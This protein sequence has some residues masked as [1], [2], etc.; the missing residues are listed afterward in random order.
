MALA[1]TTGPGGELSRTS[2][3]RH[4]G[5]GYQDLVGQRLSGSAFPKGEAEHR[6]G[7]DGS[8]CDPTDIWRGA[9]FEDRL[10]ACGQW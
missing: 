9:T 8:P 10:A 1:D 7:C 5:L 6:D 4:P 3:Q 2:A